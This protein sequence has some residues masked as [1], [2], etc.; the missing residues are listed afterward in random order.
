MGYGAPDAARLLK[1][2]LILRE[3][4]KT[5]KEMAQ[6]AEFFFKEDI[7]YETKARD[8]YLT[9]AA[10][11]VLER[12]LQGLYGPPKP[13]RGRAEGPC[14]GHRQRPRQEARGSDTTCQGG[15]LRQGSNP[16]DLRSHRDPRKGDSGKEDR[17]SHLLNHMK[18]TTLELLGFKSFLNRTTFRFNEG[19]T[20]IVGPNGCGKSN[21]VDAITWVLGERGTS[22]CASRRWATSSSTAAAPKN[23]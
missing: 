9:P 18:L 8:K 21:I 3:R 23:R 10:K 16:R 6:M 20:C 22:P 12:F 1:I 7:E 11:P 4:A 19:V 5:L 14:R 17:E 15:P 2:V 13:G